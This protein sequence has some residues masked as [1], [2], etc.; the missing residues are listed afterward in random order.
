MAAHLIQCHHSY[1]VAGYD[2]SGSGCLRHVVRCA[3]LALCHLRTKRWLYANHLKL[4]DA[5][6][7][8]L[9]TMEAVN[10]MEAVFRTADEYEYN[11]PIRP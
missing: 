11:D 6:I 10:A 7:A 9:A 1:V 2:V 5:G 3:S 4:T 8:I